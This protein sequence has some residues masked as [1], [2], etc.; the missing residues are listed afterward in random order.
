MEVSY[1]SPYAMD[2]DDDDLTEDEEY[3]DDDEIVRGRSDR[4]GGGRGDGDFVDGPFGG[5]E[6]HDFRIDDEGDDGE[7]VDRNGGGGGGNGQDQV[8]GESPYI[9]SS[10]I[11]CH[12]YWGIPVEVNCV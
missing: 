12:L 6:E 1:R 7:F 11:A 4:G 3:S 5:D 2:D 9:L 8:D 10:L